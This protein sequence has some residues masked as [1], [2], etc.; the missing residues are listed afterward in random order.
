MNGKGIRAIV[1]LFLLST[2]SACSHVFNSPVTLSTRTKPVQNA[3]L[4]KPVRAEQCDYVILSF[5][6]IPSD[7]KAIHDK[8]LDR[9]R[10]AGGNAVVDYQVAPS[11]MFM[12]VPLF[13]MGC[14]EASGTAAVVN[15]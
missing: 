12:M 5:L 2:A 15:P 11:K 10:E 6:P 13:M 1:L 4:L 8:M 3:K 7:P 9:A 14:Y